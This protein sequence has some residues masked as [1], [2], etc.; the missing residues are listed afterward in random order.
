M[1]SLGVNP[2]VN[3]LYSDLMDGRILFQIFEFIQPGIV[4]WKRVTT[5]FSSI[6]GR[7]KLEVL[8]NCN[9]A[10]ELGKK[11]NLILVGIQGDDILKANKTLTLGLVWQLMRKYTLSL[12]AKL[13]GDGTPIVETE[14]LA[15]ANQRL[16]DAGKDVKVKQFHVSLKIHRI[17]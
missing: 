16:E 7:Q 12:L 17:F 15:W 13:N 1:N 11:L 9:Y 4:N 6:E 2:Y 8:E 14:I 5:K 10:V 3:Y